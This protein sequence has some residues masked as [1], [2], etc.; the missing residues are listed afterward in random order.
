MWWTKRKSTDHA[1]KELADGLVSALGP[2][3]NS[4]LLF[5]SRASGEFQEDRSDA[6][7]FVLLEIM[8]PAAL[9][10]MSA[11]FRQWMKTGHPLPVFIQ[12]SELQTYADS[13]PIEFLDM[14]DHHR[15][16]VGSD[17][18]SG[19]VVNPSG[20][21]A[22]CMQELSVKLIK[23]RQAVLLAGED[24]KKLRAILSGSQSSV[25]ALYR[26][27]SRLDPQVPIDNDLVKRL[28]EVHVRRQTDNLKILS[29]DYLSGM[30][31]VLTY[32]H[33]K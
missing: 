6:N 33:Q 11:P 13:L 15:I 5:G 3:L 9:E 23:L 10:A 32:L 2:K 14:K 29:Q 17:P 25:R 16:I 7:V 27:A 30:E 28:K 21:R 12:K 20:L 26:A 31:R 18:L 24:E 1:L 19:L 8:S 4:V 22:Q